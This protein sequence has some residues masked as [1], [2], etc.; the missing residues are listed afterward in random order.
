M[1]EFLSDLAGEFE[2]AE[3]AHSYMESHTVSR[4]AAQIY[5]LRKQ[6]GWSQAEL[7]ERAGI[8]QERVSKI[9]SADFDSLTMKTLHKFARAFDIDLRIAFV[10]FS[11]GILDVAKLDP[12]KLEVCSRD[13]DIPRFKR[14][15]SSVGWTS[16]GISAPV[17]TTPISSMPLEASAAP[18]LVGT[19]QSAAPKVMAVMQ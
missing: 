3:Y 14:N 1:K 11:A 15:V 8:A 18:T 4:L 13:V 9:E 5:A 7:A 6:R 12:V 16:T 10:S 19:W 17:L 2:D